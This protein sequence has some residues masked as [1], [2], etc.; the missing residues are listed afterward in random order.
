M[1]SV[2][3]HLGT[4]YPRVEKQEEMVRRHLR[5]AIDAVDRDFAA[6][7]PPQGDPA[8]LE[9]LRSLLVLEGTPAEV[10]LTASGQSALS[11]ALLALCPSPGIHVA[12]EEWSFPHALK[13]LRQIGATVTILPMDDQGLLPEALEAAG[14]AG[15]RVLYTTPTVHN[16]TGVTMPMARRKEIASLA[17]RFGMFI[18]ED[19]AYA[20]LEASGIP[21][22]QALVPE[23]TIRMVSLSKV[24]SLSLRLGAVVCPPSLFGTVIERVRMM[25]GMANPVMTAG[26]ASLARAGEV[27]S[28]IAA[29]R[30][31]G[32]RRQAL[33]HTIFRDGYRAHP[34]S[35][36]GM[37]DIR[38][39]GSAFAERARR[40]GVILS[41]GGEYRADEA[42]VPA[43]RVSLGG[44]AS[45]QRLSQ[46]L[47]IVERMRET[48]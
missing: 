6:P 31:E 27:E 26:A 48:G 2:A 9:A 36:Y 23:R 7:R 1:S 35:W 28:L 8:D 14:R 11:A 46:G 13:L 4:C 43:V 25:G 12:V 32:S 47:E 21:P 34:S 15:A 18:V 33:A 22:L 19:E 3:I 41:A 5:A 20:F 16:P 10:A 38:S 17:E 44:E 37:V 42:D 39:E 45:W 29:K 24:I 40:A 30:Q